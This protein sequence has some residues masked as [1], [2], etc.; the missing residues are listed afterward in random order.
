MKKLLIYFFG[1]LV[2]FISSPAFALSTRRCNPVVP[3]TVKYRPRHAECGGKA[4]V[5][6]S[7]N[8]LNAFSVVVKKVD[9]NDRLANNC[10]DASC[11]PFKS[12]KQFTKNGVRTICFGAS[13]MSPV[14]NGYDPDY[15][16]ST[17]F[18]VRWISIKRKNSGLIK[19]VD[20]FC[21]KKPY[22]KTRVN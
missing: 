2:F 12:Q 5:L 19:D 14:F 1:V 8:Y 20:I 9:H 10:P 17:S 22:P 3:E 15:G 16:Y 13:G 7:G 11:S 18:V 6:L 21:M 4:A